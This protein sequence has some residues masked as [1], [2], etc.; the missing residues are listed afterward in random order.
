MAQ[1]LAMRYSPGR[2]I[3]H[4]WDARCKLIGLL[5]VTATL[6]RLTLTWLLLNSGILVGLLFISGLALRPLLRDLR[7]W[8][9]WLLM[10]FVV[11]VFF[12]AG[13]P[14][15]FFWGLPVSVEGVRL[16]ALTCWRVGIILGYAIILTAVTRPREI[17]DA[18]IWFLT[19]IPF[20]P[21][22]RIGLMVSLT[23]RFFSVIVDQTD[24]VMLAHK[25][26]LGDRQKNPLRKMR[27][28]VLPI[29]RRSFDRVEDVTLALL[30]RGFR[31][32]LP[33]RLSRLKISHFIPLLILLWIMLALW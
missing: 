33:L 11:Q 5:L 13:P 14:V 6:L 31:E 10:L 26:R 19:P 9:L 3:L 12:S 20:L 27:S 25:A 2:S 21:A 24:E 8:F 4:G 30:A 18:L 15:A 7:S 29:L 1:R 16:G 17:Q 32:D 23:V 22:R 28:I